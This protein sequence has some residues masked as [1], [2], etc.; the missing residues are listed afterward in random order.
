[1]VENENVAMTLYGLHK[2]DLLTSL[3][4]PTYLEDEKEIPL[5]AYTSIKN[6]N[7]YVI[8]I[9]RKFAN[10]S[11]KKDLYS[12]K[13]N[14]MSLVKEGEIKIIESNI[15]NIIKNIKLIRND[16]FMKNILNYVEYEKK[17]SKRVV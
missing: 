14:L 15:D 17:K 13:Q 10:N 12:L 9:K 6:N 8:A 3:L 7:I 4:F 1:M 16:K 11:Y 5:I 2:A